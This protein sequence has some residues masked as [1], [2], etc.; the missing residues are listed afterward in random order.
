MQI[1]VKM[2]ITA[3]FWV[4]YSLCSRFLS[5]D[6]YRTPLPKLSTGT[7]GP[8]GTAP[9]V[10]ALSAA[11]CSE[12]LCCPSPPFSLPLLFPFHSSPSECQ[13]N[14]AAL[15]DMSLCREKGTFFLGL[16]S[17]LLLIHCPPLHATSCCISA[18]S[19]TP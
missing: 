9:V 16:G 17:S 18:G 13:S 7:K 6:I 8:P 12:H 4:K 10:L 1:E 14:T 11:L 5:V 3:V 2:L 15:P 19:L